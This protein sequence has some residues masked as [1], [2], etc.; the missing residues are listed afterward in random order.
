MNVNAGSIFEYY[1]RMISTIDLTTGS[2][3]GLCHIVAFI[4]IATSVFLFVLS[5]LVFRADPTDPKN[6]FMG[7]MLITEAITAG[8]LPFF[9]LYPWSAAALPVLFKIRFL[10]LFAGQIRMLLFLFAPAFYMEG[11]IARFI[12]SLFSGWKVLFFPFFGVF[13]VAFLIWASGDIILGLGNLIHLECNSVGP[14]IGLTYSGADLPYAPYCPETYEASYPLVFHTVST[15]FMSFTLMLN[16]NVSL[17]FGLICLTVIAR[18]TK[19]MRTNEENDEIAAIRLGFVA[20]ILCTVLAT[21][22]FALL[23]SAYGSLNIDMSVFNEQ[24]FDDPGTIVFFAVIPFVFLLNIFAAF[25]EGVVFTYA[26]IKHEVMGIDEHLRKTFNATLFAGIGAIGLTASTEIMENLIG[27][28]WIGGV[29]IGVLLI[30]LRN[31]ILGLLSSFSM[32]IMPESHTKEEW[33]YIELYALALED[34]AVSA[35]S[36]AMLT[37]HAKRNGI[38]ESRMQHLEEWHLNVQQNEA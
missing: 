21:S 37:A 1:Y 30:L 12:Q 28:G 3:F 19:A 8:V 14:G 13:A 23:S 27:I 9:W 4:G 18:R 17:L 29:L 6:R 22:L 25:F 31:P 20:K 24:W 38:S 16:Q 32:L 10:N 36:R 7:M 2:I 34:G 35:T 11:T 26:I 5:A 15:G 33:G